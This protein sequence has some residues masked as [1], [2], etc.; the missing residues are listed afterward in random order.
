MKNKKLIKP[1]FAGFY[2]T[3]HCKRYTL[4]D[5]LP[6]CKL[7]SCMYLSLYVL[8]LV[9]NR[10]IKC[11]DVCGLYYRLFTHSITKGF[12]IICWAV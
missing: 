11:C 1:E 9:L 7:Y 12:L 10:N 6:K 5:N 2:I 3:L 8:I 4:K